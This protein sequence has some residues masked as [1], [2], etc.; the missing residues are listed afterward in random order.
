MEITDSEKENKATL[1]GLANGD[2]K[3]IVSVGV[4]PTSLALRMNSQTPIL[5]SMVPNVL[6]SPLI[7]QEKPVEPRLAGLATS[8]SPDERL[9]W[10]NTVCP[11]ANRIAV[12]Y[13]SRTE[14]TVQALEAATKEL[15]KN[16][17]KIKA[18]KDNF[19]NAVEEL[20]NE[21]IDSVIMI[22]DAHV[23]NA[24]TAKRL[25]LW[26]IR[27]KKPVWAFSGKIVKAGALGGQYVD[28]HDI[29]RQT[30]ELA[31]RLIEGTPP[32][33]IGLQYPDRIS[34]AVNIHTAEMIDLPVSS[35]IVG[36]GTNR[37]GE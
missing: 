24:A 28:K 26:G 14:K 1:N 22:P 4:K 31:Q 25:L 5:F 23:Y 37:F 32:T 17:I 7:E 12:L 36:E 3:L 33:D 34:R 11:Q 27:N 16:L 15:D 8:V 20:N 9:D 21:N 35:E 19:P 10:I 18:D 2:Y 13:S 6:D 30:A 29:A